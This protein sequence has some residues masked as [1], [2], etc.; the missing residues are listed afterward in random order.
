MGVLTLVAAQAFAILFVTAYSQGD[1]VLT[2]E[3][4]NGRNGGYRRDHI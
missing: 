4:E 3:R 2:P 1:G